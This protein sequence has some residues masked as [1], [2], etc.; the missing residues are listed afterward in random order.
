[1]GALHPVLFFALV[2]GISLFLALFVCRNVYYAINGEPT[3]QNKLTTSN[4]A[5]TASVDY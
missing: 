5:A 3:V 1:M 4:S 2:Y